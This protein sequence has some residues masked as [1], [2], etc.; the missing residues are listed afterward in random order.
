MIS[1][2]MDIL[3]TATV[4]VKVAILNSPTYPSIVR[5]LVLVLLVIA[6]RVV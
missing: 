5:R 3:V 2:V 6:A 1:S 4:T